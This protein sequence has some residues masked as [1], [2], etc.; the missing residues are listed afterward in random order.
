[1]RT[2]SACPDD[3]S[4]REILAALTEQHDAIRIVHVCGHGR[5]GEPRFRFARDCALD[6]RADTPR[7]LEFDG[8][9]GLGHPADLCGGRIAFSMAGSVITCRSRALR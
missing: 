3:P 6:A 8:V 4:A 2:I 1:M 9:F 7:R 5:A